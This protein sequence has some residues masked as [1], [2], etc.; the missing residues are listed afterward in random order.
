MLQSST[1]ITPSRVPSPVLPLPLRR[2]IVTVAISGTSAR[3]PRRRG[4]EGDGELFAG[5]FGE[6][7]VGVGEMSFDG[8][9]GDEQVLGDV[10]VGQ[11]GGELGDAAFAGCRRV[12]PAEDEPP[13][14]PAGGDE[15]GAGPLGQRQRGAAVGEVERGPQDVPAFGPVSGPLE[16]RP[17]GRS[18]RGRAP[19]ARRSRRARRRPG[20][21]SSIP[22]RLPG[23]GCTDERKVAGGEEVAEGRRRPE[24]GQPQPAA[25][26]EHRS[27][28]QHRRTLLGEAVPLTRRLGAAPAARA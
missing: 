14:P 25:G 10:A 26:R 13:G 4:W 7:V 16:G 22:A 21:S 28:V 23:S 17:R 5:G 19:I 8:P 9:G 12:E 1:Q 18:W 6:L 3:W 20:R 11:A 2:A 24:L 15:F 27:C